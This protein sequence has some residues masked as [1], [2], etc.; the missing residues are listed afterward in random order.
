MSR[1]PT[2]SP[3]YEPSPRRSPHTANTE[4]DRERALRVRIANVLDEVER[5]RDELIDIGRELGT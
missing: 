1:W 2:D 4:T 5:L 3:F